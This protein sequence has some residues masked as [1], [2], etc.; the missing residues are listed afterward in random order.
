MTRTLLPRLTARLLAEGIP[1]ARTQAEYLLSSALG[2]RRLDLYLLPDIPRLD[3]AALR[4]L[5]ADCERLARH[6]P[7]QYVLGETEFM[8]RRFRSDPRALIPRPETE[9]LV[10]HAL[11]L[12]P[13][14]R[15]PAPGIVEAGTGSGC[16]AVT[17]RLERPGAAV[18]A[19]DCSPEALALA[20]ENAVALH[21]DRIDWRLCDLLDG[22]PPRSMDLVISNP[23]Y[24]ATDE[25]DGLDR[26]VRD[27]EPRLALDGGAD[28]LDVIRRLASQA[29]HVLRPGGQLL[30][31]IGEDQ[32]TA[33]PGILTQHGYTA[34]R[35]LR[36]MNGHHRVVTAHSAAQPRI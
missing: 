28:G 17:L 24:I 31:E 27:H 10:R 5:D 13:A 12:L 6:E 22:I 7:L 3:A 25:L 16:I 36:D 9:E 4:R 26:N 32:G 11:E 30:L 21:A 14:G 34:V 15:T 1:E 8:G 23:P 35:V 19:T 29:A 20:R 18:T 2:V 33:V